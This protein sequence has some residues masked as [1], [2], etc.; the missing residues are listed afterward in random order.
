MAVAGQIVRIGRAQGALE[1]PVAHG[2][3]VD[4]QIL[5]RRIAPVV[6]RQARE[7]GQ[8]HAVAQLVDLQRILV[9]LPAQDGRQP[10]QPPLRP[11]G[12]SGQAQHPAAVQVQGEGHRLMGHGLALDLL[13]D[14]HGFGP[15]GLHELQPRRGGVEEVAHLDPRPMGAGKG[16]GRRLAHG[17][18]LDQQRK[19]V[20]RAARP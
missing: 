6:G 7:P 10:R 15:L 2:P 9:E 13:G 12:L 20:G 17:P 18:A 14:G 1:K 16:G 5:M 11:M 3:A 4:E 19:G 8:P